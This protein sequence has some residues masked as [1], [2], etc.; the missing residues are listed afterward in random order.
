MGLWVLAALLGGCG[1][2][3]DWVGGN[4]AGAPG[5]LQAALSPGAR[6]LIARA[7]DGIDRER[8]VDFHVHLVGSED[9][10]H[11]AFVN[12]SARSWLH[13][14]RRAQ[15]Q[16]YLSASG[17]A[18]G[19][20]LDEQYLAR[21][22]D[23][24]RHT[25][26]HGRY[27]IYA[28]D[29]H[30]RPDGTPDPE[31]TPFYVPNEYVFSLAR[32]Y[33]D[34]LVPVI[35][36]HPYRADA[37]QELDKWSQR[38][39]RYV[40]W[41]P[42]S[43][44]IDPSSELAEPFYRKLKKHK[45]VLLVHTGRELAVYAWGHQHLGNP[46]LLRKPLDMGVTVVALHSA[47]D[48]K[49]VDLDSPERRKVPSF[50][51][52]MR[53]MDEPRSAGLLYGEISALTFF[54]HLSRPL[55]TLLARKDLHHRLING[56]DYPLPGINLLIMTRRLVGEGFLTE[57]ERGYLNEIYRYN[58]LLFDF[59]V[60]RTVHHPQTGQRF[61]ASVFMQPGDLLE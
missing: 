2:L 20:R 49:S 22:L 41:L 48:G 39:L 47:S 10:D 43:M 44:G 18:D 29:R 60:K 3:Y 1:W 46:L 13:P 19:S 61:P 23:L 50:D 45:M 57:E 4:F 52:F 51:L 38:G 7:F 16:V 58:P 30:Y 56:S 15:F 28:M 32:Q 12:P 27:F 35:S 11:G 8:L 53:L 34:L 31:Q 55:A 54:N 17:V 25:P 37:L 21:L 14:I 40:K 59:V 6:A 24:I 9:G 26:S 42:N 33:P 5:E 36:I